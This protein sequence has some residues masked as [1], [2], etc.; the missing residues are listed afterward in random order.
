MSTVLELKNV[1]KAF[2]GVQAV[3]DMSFVI[4]R[5]E[6]AGL[7]GPN[8]AGK[9]TIFNLITGVYDVTS[10]DIEF[11]GNNINKLKTF[12]VI[13]LGIARTFQ[14][15]RLFAASSVLEN[16]MTAA[17]QHYKYNFFEAV[18]HLGRW[19]SKESATRKESMELLERVGLA[20]RADQ[21]AGTLPYGLQRRLEIARA[22]SLKPELLL[23][24]EPAAGMNA[25]EVEQLNHL[26]TDIHKDF[27][28]TILLIEHHMDMVMEICPHIVCMN[29]GAK[30]AEGTP[31]EIQSHPD[32][33]KAYL[34]EEE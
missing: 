22:I 26:I 11:K 4:N 1:N 27:N 15:L 28:L 10:G 25:E 24:D 12:Q 30:I 34:G 32:V 20:D 2:G 13:S 29:F 5:G 3:H 17:Q 7:I 14:N 16:V 18:S 19:K 9:T 23:L 31:E 33:L 21:A 6:L 8:G